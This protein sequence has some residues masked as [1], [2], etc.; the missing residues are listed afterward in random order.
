MLFGPIF[1]VDANLW[2]KMFIPVFNNSFSNILAANTISLL[3]L[4][5]W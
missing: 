2:F 1:H 5:L 4:T 3:M